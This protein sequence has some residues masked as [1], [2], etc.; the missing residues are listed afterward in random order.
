MKERIIQKTD[1]H[2]ELRIGIAYYLV[3]CFPAVPYETARRI[4]DDAVERMLG[5]VREA[6]K[7]EAS[8]E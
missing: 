4:A 3:G 2:F 8:N 5:A 6:E 7:E 1:E